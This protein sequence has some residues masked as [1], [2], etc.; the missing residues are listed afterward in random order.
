[1]N[2]INKRLFF[3]ALSFTTM[4]LIVVAN[5]YGLK[6]GKKMEYAMKMTS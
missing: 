1:M 3:Q 6:S 4:K 2:K 5:H